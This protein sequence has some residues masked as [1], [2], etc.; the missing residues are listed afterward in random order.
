MTQEDLYELNRA[1]KI[2]AHILYKNTPSERLQDFESM[3][4]AVHDHFLKTVGPELLKFF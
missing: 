2:I 3:G 1:L 4:L